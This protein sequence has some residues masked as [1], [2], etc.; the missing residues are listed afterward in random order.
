[1]ASL[2]DRLL[3]ALRRDGWESLMRS[4]IPDLNQNQRETV[5]ALAAHLV[6]ADRQIQPI[7]ASFLEALS[8]A[9]ELPDGRA[10][11]ILDVVSILHRDC[12][13]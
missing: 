10:D 11:Q 13:V 4:A 2:F 8:Q 7:E 9:L 3:L 5:L 12:L 6:R 1:M